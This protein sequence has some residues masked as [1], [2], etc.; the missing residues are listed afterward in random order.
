MSRDDFHIA[1]FSPT[2]LIIGMASEYFGGSRPN[3]E[4]GGLE[5]FYPHETAIADFYERCLARLQAEAALTT[6][7]ERT[8]SGIGHS[9][10]HS[11]ALAAVLAAAY[12]EEA[13]IADSMFPPYLNREEEFQRIER[14]SFDE[15]QAP[16]REWED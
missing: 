10:F 4:R 7:V 16:L 2:F 5:G 11:P 14:A 12:G 3:P 1:T 8:T 6:S 15:T 13:G 9:E